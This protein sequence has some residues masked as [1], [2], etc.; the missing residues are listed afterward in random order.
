MQNPFR[1]RHWARS[2][3]VVVEPNTTTISSSSNN[4]GSCRPHPA[5]ISRQFPASVLPLTP[6]TT[7]ARNPTRSS[8]D[9]VRLLNRKQLTSFFSL[10]FFQFWMTHSIY[11]S[12]FTADP[13][14][15]FG[16]NPIAS[17]Q[18]TIAAVHVESSTD[19]RFVVAHSRQI[20]VSCGCRSAEYQ[21]EQR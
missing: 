3:V 15:K 7:T 9:Q 11:S 4:Y 14:G 17:S 18:Q 19:G 8:T 20:V 5:I 10:A 13:Q 21:H 2:V 6:K 1:F 16:S 12:G